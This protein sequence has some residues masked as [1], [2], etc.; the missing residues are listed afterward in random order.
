MLPDQVGVKLFDGMEADGQACR[1]QVAAI[2]GLLRRLVEGIAV[3]LGPFAGGADVELVPDDRDVDHAFDTAVVVIADVDGAHRFILIGGLCRDQVHDACGRI[4][5]IE[6][7]LRTAQHFHLRNVEEFLFEEMVADERCV[8]EGDGNRRIGG[9]GDGLCAD[10]ADLDVVAGEVGFC[11]RQ[12]RDVLDEIGA[13]GGL[14]RGKLFLAERGDRN[15][16]ALHILTTELGRGDGHGFDRASW[17][18]AQLR[19][20]D[21]V[22]DRLVGLGACIAHDGHGTR[23]AVLHDEAR[24]A[25][26]FGERVFRRHRAGHAAGVDAFDGVVGIHQAD[27]RLLGI[28]V[29]CGFEI[30][31]RNVEIGSGGDP[32][33]RY[34]AGAARENRLYVGKP[35][36]NSPLWYR[37][38]ARDDG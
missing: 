37:V 35:D 38:S 30:A 12:V 16:D 24:T 34:G 3:A 20:L 33:K 6:R 36:Q 31:A 28:G 14:R 27:S 15:R 4:A 17:G 26:Q 11:E 22:F 7:A 18:S 29:E 32:E 13:A 2:D 1:P 5:A 9:H 10:A 21:R 19:K 23:R 25:Q 8:V